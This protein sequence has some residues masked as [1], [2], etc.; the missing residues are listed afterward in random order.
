M[1]S[2]R[3]TLDGAVAGDAV[4]VAVSAG[5]RRAADA[6][7]AG[8]AVVDAWPDGVI[9]VLDHAGPAAAG[10]STERPVGPDSVKE[11]RT[12]RLPRV[13]DDEGW[14]AVVAAFAS[15]AAAFRQRGIRVVVAVSD[16]GLL[17]AC[18]SPLMCRPPQPAR[19][20]AVLRACAPCDVLVVVEDLAPLGL[21]ATDGTALARGFVVD[22]GATTLFATAGT[23]RL[24]PLKDRDK[25][26]SVDVDGAFLFSAA[27]C[28]RAGFDVPV[29]AVGRSA[30]PPDRLAR[31]ARALGLHGVVVV[32]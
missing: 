31:R 13:L 16:D 25:G 3:S 2:L 27:W 6:L 22:A 10:W 11:S 17:H 21:D 9:P 5:G 26:S 19:V 14:G 18:I 20:A 8:A 30:A 1:A 7:V 29:V 23:D 24:A 32:V 15:A 4:V 28:V 12:G